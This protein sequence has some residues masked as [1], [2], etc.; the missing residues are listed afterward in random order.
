MAPITRHTNA[1]MLVRRCAVISFQCAIVL[2]RFPKGTELDRAVIHRTA[3]N[4][5][6]AFECSAGTTDAGE[7]DAL[8]QSADN[9]TRTAIDILTLALRS[10]V[11]PRP[12]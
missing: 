5:W 10:H 4:A 7:I 6:H 9:L 11:A 1:T 3:D 2:D 12:D 8:A